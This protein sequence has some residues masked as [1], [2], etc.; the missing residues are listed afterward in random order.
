MQAHYPLNKPPIG[1]IARKKRLVARS[2]RRRRQELSDLQ[3]DLDA[4]LSLHQPEALRVAL[5]FLPPSHPKRYTQL[6]VPIPVL[7]EV[8]ARRTRAQEPIFTAAV[9]TPA[10]QR[11]RFSCTR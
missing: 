10:K 1:K 9:G 4:A 8:S 7:G 3:A 6:P 5:L 11:W 2:C